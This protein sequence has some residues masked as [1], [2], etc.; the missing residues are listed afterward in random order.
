MITAVN[1]LFY[2]IGLRSMGVLALLLLALPTQAAMQASK[3]DARSVARLYSA[4]FDREPKTEGLNFWIDRFESGMSI[5]E[6][7][8]SFNSSNEFSTK[9]GPLSNR[10][11][12]QQLFR[13]VLGREGNESGITYWTD[14]INSGR[15][16]R[17]NVLYSFSKSPEN[18]SKTSELYKYMA[19]GADG[20]WG[21][22]APGQNASSLNGSYH[23]S[24]LHPEN[25][26]F[27]DSVDITITIGNSDIQIDQQAFFGNDCKFEGVITSFDRSKTSATAKGTYK[28]SDFSAG[29]WTSERIAKTSSDTLVAEILTNDGK[30]TATSKFAIF[31]FAG[32]PISAPALIDS[33]SHT[34]LAGHYEGHMKASNQTC[35]TGPRGIFTTGTQIDVS[36]SNIS[37]TQD[38][39]LEGICKFTGKLNTSVSPPYTAS[40][41]YQ[42][43]NFNEGSWKSDYLTLTG[44]DSFLAKLDV[45][46]TD[47]ACG[48]SIK[49]LGFRPDPVSI[50]PNQPEVPQQ[51]SIKLEKVSFMGTDEVP[52][53]YLCTVSTCS[54][55]SRA[56]ILGAS[57][58]KHSSYILTAYG[59]DFVV[60]NLVASDSNNVT[61]VG[62]D[63]L[64]EGQLI[65]QGQ[66]VEFSL[67]SGLTNGK[68]ASL[69]W[70]FEIDDLGVQFSDVLNLT[71]N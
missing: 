49:Y 30:N 12:V 36:G 51:T 35:N 39:F 19:E 54:K 21:Y 14:L 45:K 34:D 32:S 70:S 8:R 52:L 16:T 33:G 29:T 7:A 67:T 23:G 47:Q 60:H 11:F 59:K 53:P 61:S 28:C 44:P 58:I 48:Y 20:S 40:G 3:E 37:I 56:T 71:T 24:M 27:T 65:P 42:C 31:A 46:V 26:F 41:T 68:Q 5:Q 6:I 1:R 69:F 66:S 64:R 55:S 4:A 22:E 17:A 10:E 9:Y 38:S 2:S 25:I 13:N 62:F 50:N 18:V 15:S 63:G 43:S 57:T